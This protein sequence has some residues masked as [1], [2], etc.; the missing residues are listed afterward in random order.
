[1]FTWG[2]KGWRIMSF[3]VS[4]GLLGWGTY[5]MVTAFLAGSPIWWYNSSIMVF[6]FTL[7]GLAFLVRE[8]FKTFNNLVKYGRNPASRQT[9]EQGQASMD[10]EPRSLEEQMDIQIDEPHYDEE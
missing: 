6:G 10:D 9:T 7:L 2:T 8:G 5:G 3:I 1:M 4:I